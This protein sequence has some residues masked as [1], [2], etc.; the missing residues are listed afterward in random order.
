MSCPR[1]REPRGYYV[2]QVA[3]IL[4]LACDGNGAEYDPEY[5]AEHDDEQVDDFGW[6]DEL[7]PGEH[8]T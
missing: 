1:D 7:F 4:G 5:N 3:G 8:D 2:A 6:L